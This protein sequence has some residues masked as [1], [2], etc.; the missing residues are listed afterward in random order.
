MFG[1]GA[2]GFF[3]SATLYEL[4]S[5]FL[6]ILLGIIAML[7]AGKKLFKPYFEKRPVM[8]VIPCIV[9]FVLC[10]VYLADASYNPFLYFRF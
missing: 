2:E 8:A 3:S 9:I 7:P 5:N 1:V 10:L 6:M 4:R